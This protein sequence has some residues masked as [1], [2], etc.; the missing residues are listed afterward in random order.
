MNRFLGI[1]ILLA[2]LLLP[3]A[4]DCQQ[5]RVAVLEFRNL[6][7]LT[8]EEAAFLT[9]TVRSVAILLPGEA[10]RIIT[11]ENILELLPPGT[12]L[13]DCE[14]ECEIATGRNVGAN[15]VVSGEVITFGRVLKV[16]L[17]LHDTTTSA[18]L[19][20]QTA[21]AEHVQQLEQQ[22]Y[23]AA[24][25]LFEVLPGGQAMARN[26]AGRLHPA[27]GSVQ[28]T[29]PARTT[30][31]AEEAKPSTT[32][33]DAT[34]LLYV[35]TEPEGATVLVDGR[36]VGKTPY[37]DLKLAPGYHVVVVEY[38]DLYHPD[39]WSGQIPAEGRHLSFPL[40]PHFGSLLIETEPPG[41]EC[42]LDGI[43]LPGRTPLLRKQQVSRTYRVACT[44]R[45]YFEAE[46]V[47]IVE[48]EEQAR[49]RLTLEAN[50]GRL[51]VDST[52]RGASVLLDDATSP[53]G[54]TPLILERA[55]LGGRKIRLQKTGHRDWDGQVMVRSSQ[56]A[57]VRPVLEPVFG[58]LQVSASSRDGGDNRPVRAKVTV[59]GSP[60]GETP[61]KDKVPT[62]PHVVR[63]AS[64]FGDTEP[65]TVEVFEGRTAEVFFQLD[66]K[67]PRSSAVA[68]P[69]VVRK[70]APANRR[71]IQRKAGL[72]FTAMGL[73]GLLAGGLAHGI[74]KEKA[75]D[76]IGKMD[77]PRYDQ[78]RTG[79][80]AAYGLYGTGALLGIIGVSLLAT[81]P[82][83]PGSQGGTSK[84]L[85]GIPAP[86]VT[87][88]MVGASWNASF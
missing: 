22:T 25:R 11:K 70:K 55:P 64:P 53:V 46:Q 27:G 75:E 85:A 33:E 74:S 39:S 12:D 60:V 24:V 76:A 35:S 48:D 6:S 79:Y 5:K 58:K 50:F 30:A 81:L 56:V 73:A 62:G 49:V 26:L 43:P 8:P 52:P 28:V 32:G 63:V 1:P 3:H 71:A 84:A 78:A 65:R 17:K 68:P 31:Q 2:C 13:A 80:H 38:A 86:L 10:Y 83:N 20:F 40:K 45:D 19:N 88:T 82:Q 9:D 34:A 23:A 36:V 7:S 87:P 69:Q 16:S 66:P 21:S 4:A 67:P 61:W 41:A 29:V 72:A 47:V 54:R 44:A 51:E 42:R 18:L 59:D 57:H 77:R 14:G 15:L 37:Q